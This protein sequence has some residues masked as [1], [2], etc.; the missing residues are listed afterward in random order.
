M[1]AVKCDFLVI[2]PVRRFTIY[3]LDTSPQF[4]M[5]CLMIQRLRK[6]SPLLS[7]MFV[8]YSGDL[9]I[10]RL[11][12]GR[13]RVS[14][15]EV[16]SSSHL[17]QYLCWNSLCVESVS[18]RGYVVGCCFNQGRSFLLLTVGRESYFA[19]FVSIVFNLSTLSVPV[20]FSFSS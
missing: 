14:R 9:I 4:G 6:L 20:F 1:R 12:G 18:S 10:H 19:Q 13:G 5:F 3:C 11:Q 8:R 7:F 2:S 16:S 17:F 15:F